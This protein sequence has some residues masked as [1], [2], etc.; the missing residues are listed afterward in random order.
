MKR[1]LVRIHHSTHPP[2]RLKLRPGTKVSDV[3]A[4]L[5]L[6]ED[7]VL[8]PISDPSKIFTPEEVLYDLIKNDEKLIARAPV[9]IDIDKAREE[10]MK[11]VELNDDPPSEPVA[12][13]CFCDPHMQD[14]GLVSKTKV[15]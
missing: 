6:N 5:N 8:S 12:Q 4:Y 11:Y 14:R 10:M 9:K 7:Y 2:Y 15:F 3:L 1:F 13:G